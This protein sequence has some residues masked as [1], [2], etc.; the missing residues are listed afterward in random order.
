M[1]LAALEIVSVLLPCE[2]QAQLQRRTSILNDGILIYFS[3]L[4]LLTLLLAVLAAAVLVACIALMLLC[5]CVV[6]LLPLSASI[7]P[8][9][10]H[11]SG[12]RMIE[13]YRLVAA[14]AVACSCRC[15]LLRGCIFHFVCCVAVR[16]V[17][18][19]EP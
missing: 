14:G 7:S 5:C 4:T 18:V 12:A 16:A 6:V 10:L 19:S 11:L 17:R 1:L 3:L 9:D 8:A 15:W 13:R 2:E